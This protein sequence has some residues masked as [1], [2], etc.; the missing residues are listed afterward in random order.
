MEEAG[1]PVDA[2]YWFGLVAPAG[3]PPAVI[4]KLEKALA[5]VLQMPDVRKRLTEMGAVVTPLSG[6]E[7]GDYIRT[8]IAKWADIVAKAGVKPE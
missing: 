3:T 4:A 7:F 6:K 8:E 2:S 5:E 1:Y